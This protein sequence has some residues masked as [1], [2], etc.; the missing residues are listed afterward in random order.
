[1]KPLILFGGLVSIH[2]FTY[3]FVLSQAK[4]D[5]MSLDIPYTDYNY[6]DNKDAAKKQEQSVLVDKLNEESV[7]RMKERIA[8]QKENQ[9]EEI[10]FTQFLNK[11]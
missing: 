9:Q 6:S 10:N 7:K 1:M 11:Q 2:E 4:I 8:R 5:I 3:R